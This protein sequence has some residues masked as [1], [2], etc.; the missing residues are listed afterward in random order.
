MQEL[1]LPSEL[2][3]YHKYLF[4]DTCGYDRGIGKYVI[5]TR[6]PYPDDFKT[7]YWVEHP[8]FLG[9]ML[10]FTQG[11]IGKISKQSGG[12]IRDF[13]F[14][15]PWSK[16]DRVSIRGGSGG[17]DRVPCVY[18]HRDAIIDC[19]DQLPDDSVLEILELDTN[20]LGLF[21]KRARIVWIRPV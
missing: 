1:V 11:F 2:A 12:Q 4:I 16:A 15:S 19:P 17:G 7:P 6:F 5:R 18:C 9:Q 20:H 14:V 10:V 13:A 8:V 21:V 3:Q